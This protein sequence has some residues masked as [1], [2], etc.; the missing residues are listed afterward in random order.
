MLLLSI[1]QIP[2]SIP[3]INLYFSSQHYRYQPPKVRPPKIQPVTKQNEPSAVDVVDEEEEEEEE[4]DEWSTP[5]GQ[6]WCPFCTMIFRNRMAL[7]KH[8]F[9]R[10]HE[11]AIGGYVEPVKEPEKIEVY[12]EGTYI[13][14]IHLLL[15]CSGAYITS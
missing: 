2:I 10:Q 12:E 13:N 11:I 9:S 15:I 6:P 3:H 1:P 4:Y 7:D 14:A 8:K 5:D